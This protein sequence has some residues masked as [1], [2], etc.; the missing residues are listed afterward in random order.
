MIIFERKSEAPGPYYLEGSD[1]TH[2]DLQAAVREAHDIVHAYAYGKSLEVL[3]RGGE[4]VGV[5]LR[6]A[7]EYCKR[8][9]RSGFAVEV[10]GHSTHRRTP[11]QSGHGRHRR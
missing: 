8:R 2:R 10:E 11:R 6:A 7:P 1:T 9:V 4:V 3:G 5:V